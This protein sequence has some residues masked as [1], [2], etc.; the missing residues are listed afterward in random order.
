MWILY[1]GVL[2]S[3][4]ALLD[5]VERPDDEAIYEALEGNL[6]RCTGYQPIIDS[7]KSVLDET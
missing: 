4:K 5:R 6:C 7:I 2:M 3:V 1:P